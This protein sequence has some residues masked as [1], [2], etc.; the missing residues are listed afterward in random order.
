M[1]S[2]PE[3][4][5]TKVRNLLDKP[6]TQLIVS[7]ASVF[8]I[9]TKWKTGKLPGYEPFVHNIEEQLADIDSIELA[10]THRH[11]KHA[12]MLRLVH[13]DPFD[14]ILIAQSIIEEIPLVSRDHLFDKY[15]VS[16]IW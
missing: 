3:E 7:S 16:R 9:A 15:G 11:A 8:E 5:S 14:R 12:G 13:K 1:A 10:I 4:L 6:S 2:K